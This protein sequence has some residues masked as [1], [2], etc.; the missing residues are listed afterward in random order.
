M[1]AVYP[2]PVKLYFSWGEKDIQACSYHKN[3]RRRTVKGLL[4][5]SGCTSMWVS[6]TLCY[7]RPNKTYLGKFINV[8]ITVFCHASP[9]GT[10][11]TA[12]KYKVRIWEVAPRWTDR[13]TM[14]ISL[15]PYS[16]F[17]HATR[18]LPLSRN[19][20]LFWFSP[21]L[22]ICSCPNFFSGPHPPL[23]LNNL[24]TWLRSSHLL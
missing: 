22:T 5:T 16:G 4:C 24:S 8:R 6:C 9:I 18:L 3:K 21:L 1:I 7:L 15:S 11:S 23:R 10:I 14:N 2:V 19:L 12:L 17:P 20:F 13:K